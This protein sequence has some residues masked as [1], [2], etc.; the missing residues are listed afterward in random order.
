LKSRPG[1]AGVHHNFG[2]LLLKI[3]RIDEAVIHFE[4]ALR[5]KPEYAEAY[6]SLGAAM[7]S[8]G[9]M[10]EAIGHFKAALQIKPDFVDART[11]FKNL[12]AYIR[13]NSKKNINIDIK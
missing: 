7:V 3:G 2:V 12:S 4:A 1:F 5:I 6:N 11:N 10:V 13:A 9:K 8:K